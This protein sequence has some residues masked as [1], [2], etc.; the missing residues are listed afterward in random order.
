[1]VQRACVKKKKKKSQLLIKSM[2]TLNMG[3]LLIQIKMNET[4]K[5]QQD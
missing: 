1:M 2:Q 3:M 4:V 5:R